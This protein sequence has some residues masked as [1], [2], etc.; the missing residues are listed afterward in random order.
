MSVGFVMDFSLLLI[1]FIF[2]VPVSVARCLMV[3]TLGGNRF[4]L[5]LLHVLQEIGIKTSITVTQAINLSSLFL[6]IKKG[7]KEEEEEEEER[8]ERE[9]DR[10]RERQRE[11]ERDRERQRERA[12]VSP[13]VSTP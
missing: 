9:R 10:D 2:N 13:S 1:D 8:R 4:R 5:K 6:I 11:T 12:S 7:E 3:H